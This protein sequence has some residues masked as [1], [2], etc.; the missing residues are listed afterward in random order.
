MDVVDYY[1]GEIRNQ[2]YWMS[3]YRQESTT[4]Y[5]NSGMSEIGEVRVSISTPSSSHE[6]TTEGTGQEVSLKGL[7][8]PTDNRSTTV[9]VGDEL[10]SQPDE[11]KRYV[12]ETRDGIPNDFNPEIVHLGLKQANQSE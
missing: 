3:L 5:D 10:R 2:G 12:V 7:I 8:D 4:T 11:R 6:V 1:R 9:Q